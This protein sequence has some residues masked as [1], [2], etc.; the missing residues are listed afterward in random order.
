MSSRRY[1]ST[2]RQARAAEGRRRVVE[3]AHVL[4][5]EHG[6]AATT[7]AS[8]AEAADVSIPTVYAGFDGK[9]DLLKRAIDFA[10]AGDTEP[11]AVRDRPTAAWVHEATTAHELLS[12]FAVQMGEIAER[13]VPVY[14]VLVR[15]ADVDP[16]LAALLADLER[17]RLRAATGIARGVRDRGGLPD[18]RDVAWARDVIWVCN[19]PENYTMLVLRRG[20]ST[21]RYVDWAR[22]A[23]TRLVLDPAP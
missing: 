6:Y 21:R 9:A 11:V 23:L 16:E 10:I 7:I 3:A 19:A 20:W 2:R 22:T 4:F 5:V 17:Q 8:I 15:A 14:N 12:R 1:D 18:G 13:A